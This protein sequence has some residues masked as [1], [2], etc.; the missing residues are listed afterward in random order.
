[1]AGLLS[2]TVDIQHYGN[3][4]A[5]LAAPL[6]L[7]ETRLAEYLARHGLET[8]CPP[9]LPLLLQDLAGLGREAIETA[10][11]PPEPDSD[12]YRLGILYVLEGSHLG[13]AV[14]AKHLARCLPDAPRQYFF[15]SGNPLPRWQ[16]FWRHAGGLNDCCNLPEIIAGAMDTFAFYAQHFNACHPDAHP[17]A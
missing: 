6:H 17:N 10:C 3:A 12:S 16:A 11:A 7:L 2:P 13:G 14:I 8:T 4:L 9:R 5:V 15:S 1:M